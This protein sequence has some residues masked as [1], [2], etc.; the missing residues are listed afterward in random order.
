MDLAPR[1]R[2]QTKEGAPTPVPSGAPVHVGAVSSG[3]TQFHR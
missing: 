2:T 3:S 1:G